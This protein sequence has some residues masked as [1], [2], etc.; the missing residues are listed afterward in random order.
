LA[1][2]NNIYIFSPTVKTTS[3]T[4]PITPPARIEGVKVLHVHTASSKVLPGVNCL[5]VRVFPEYL[6]LISGLAL[7]LAFAANTEVMNAFVVDFIKISAVAAV[8][9]GDT[10]R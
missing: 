2:I 5:S 1:K 3:K 7:C 9:V 4:P 6:L 10:S 8:T